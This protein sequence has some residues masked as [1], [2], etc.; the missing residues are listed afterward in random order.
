[1]LCGANPRTP[2]VQNVPGVLR[3]RPADDR[4]VANSDGAGNSTDVQ[5]VLVGGHDLILEL[6]VVACAL[7]LEDERASARQAL[8]SLVPVLGVAVLADG[9]AAAAPANV[10]DGR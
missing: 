4:L 2:C 9:V 7:R 10:D 3:G 6:L 5:A 1:M 8:G